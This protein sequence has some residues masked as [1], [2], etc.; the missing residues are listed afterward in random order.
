MNLKQSRWKIAA[1]VLLV[2]L[3]AGCGRSPQPT[4]EATIDTAP[5]FSLIQTQAVETAVAELTANAPS[6]TPQ[7]VVTET[8]TLAPAEPTATP[9]EGP[10]QTALVPTFTPTS[11][12]TIVPT[13]IP[14]STRVPVLITNTP[15]A[16]VTVTGYSC[17]LLESTPAFGYDLPPGGDFD[18]RWVIRNNGSVS[19]TANEIDLV[20]VSG[21]RFQ[22]AD[23]TSLDLPAVASGASH[24]IVLDM[25]APRD[26]GRYSANW[27]IRRGSQ[28]LCSLPLAIDVVTP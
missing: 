15:N 10:T 26:A 25:L 12:P 24:T 18:G 27:E 3:L 14:T 28:V 22:E 9:T 1:A 16:T 20:F 8:P 6:A 5:T 11:I 23:I 2:A 4:L 7:S 19:W 13:V 17:Q 21:T